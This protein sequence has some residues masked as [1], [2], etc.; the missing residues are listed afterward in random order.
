VVCARGH[1]GAGARLVD[2]LAL[3]GAEVAAG[4]ALERAV[5]FDKEV[6]RDG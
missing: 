2:S 1:V 6:W 3:P 5:A 4:A